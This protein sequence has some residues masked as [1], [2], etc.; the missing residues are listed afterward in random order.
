M[1]HPWLNFFPDQDPPRFGNAGG[2]VSLGPPY[3]FCRP[4][5]LRETTTRNPSRAFLISRA[6]PGDPAGQAHPDGPEQDDVEHQAG[7]RIPGDVFVAG[8]ERT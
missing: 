5:G 3:I 7:Q 8:T 4:H 2:L 1:F 6:P